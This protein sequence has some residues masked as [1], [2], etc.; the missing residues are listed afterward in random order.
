MGKINLLHV[1]DFFARKLKN[2]TPF[3]Q[4]LFQYDMPFLFSTVPLHVRHITGGGQS[5]QDTAQYPNNGQNEKTKILRAQKKSSFS[6][7]IFLTTF[8]HPTPD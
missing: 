8:L 7:F 6:P 1:T 5:A 2:E 4:Y 3:S